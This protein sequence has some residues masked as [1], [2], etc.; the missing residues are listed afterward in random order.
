MNRRRSN[1]NQRD[2]H[3]YVYNPVD[4]YMTLYNDFV[5]YDVECN[6][7]FIRA[8]NNT[9][10]IA[11]LQRL[12]VYIDNITH[13]ITD[14]INSHLFQTLNDNMKS[15]L[16]EVYKDGKFRRHVINVQRVGSSFFRHEGNYESDLVLTI[17]NKYRSLN[18]LHDNMKSDLLRLYKHGKFRRHVTDVQDFGP[19]FFRRGNDESELALTIINKYRSLNRLLDNPT[20]T[21]INH[22]TGFGQRF[23]SSYYYY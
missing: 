4:D 12:N 7:E 3:N 14:T 6:S 15:D 1:N 10:P 18:R 19:S 22:M 11:R 16:L 17:I 23:P 21:S 20:T 13:Y 8:N 9:N 2:A 5:A